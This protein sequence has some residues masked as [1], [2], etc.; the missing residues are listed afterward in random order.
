MG[1]RSTGTFWRCTLFRRA[2]TCESASVGGD[3]GLG[4]GMHSF[5]RVVMMKTMQMWCVVFWFRC[6]VCCVNGERKDKW[7]GPQPEA[8]SGQLVPFAFMLARRSSSPSFVRNSLWP[9]LQQGTTR[10]GFKN[11]LGSACRNPN[12][13]YLV[14][15]VSVCPAL[16][17]LLLAVIVQVEE[18]LLSIATKLSSFYVLADVFFRFLSAHFGNTVVN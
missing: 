10:L 12:P 8:A 4:L 15:P 3:G 11:L 5:G 17:A 16:L 18:L 9:L 1:D 13:K 2:V 7:E 6:F 14:P